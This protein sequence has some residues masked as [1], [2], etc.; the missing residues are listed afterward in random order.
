MAAILEQ[1]PPPP[2]TF[3]PKI[4]EVLERIIA[5]CL[6]KDPQQR[7]QSARDLHVSLKDL[8]SGSLSVQPAAWWR[9]SRSAR[10]R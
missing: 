7:L 9:A 4:P 3:K 8:L 5:H 6:E 10:P 1:D 2:S